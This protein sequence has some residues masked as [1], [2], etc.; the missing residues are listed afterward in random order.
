MYN[1]KVLICEHGPNNYKLIMMKY[2]VDDT[3]SVFLTHAVMAGLGGLLARL[4]I[5]P[6]LDDLL[7]LYNTSHTQYGLAYRI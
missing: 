6:K 3:F 1:I 4:L 2:V 5:N 7:Y